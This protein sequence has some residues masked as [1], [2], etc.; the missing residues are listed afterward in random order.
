MHTDIQCTHWL[1]AWGLRVARASC[2][3]WCHHKWTMR[4]PAYK[5]RKW[6]PDH[7][8]ARSPTLIHQFKLY[9]HYKYIHTYIPTDDHVPKQSIFRN[10]VFPNVDLEDNLGVPIINTPFLIC[11]QAGLVSPDC[12]EQLLIAL[13]P[14]AASIYCRKLRLHQVIDLSLQ[15]LTNGFDLEGSRPLDSSFRQGE[16]ERERSCVLMSVDWNIIVFLEMFFFCIFFL[17]L[18]IVAFCNM[19][20]SVCFCSNEGK[21]LVSDTVCS[22]ASW[23]CSYECICGGAHHVYC[24]ADTLWC[25]EWILEQHFFKSFCSLAEDISC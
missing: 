18:G 21:D 9:S 13:E 16:C 5:H 6:C 19:C 1:P 17:R 10:C 11:L 24:R 15:P 14:E 8:P 4:R 7:R 20:L 22:Y 12:P 3:W 2:W 23:L 25:I